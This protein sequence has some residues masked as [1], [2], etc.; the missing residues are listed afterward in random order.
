VTNFDTF[1]VITTLNVT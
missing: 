1:L